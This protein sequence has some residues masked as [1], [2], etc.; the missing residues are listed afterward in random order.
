MGM[1]WS[2][3]GPIAVE[4]AR[5]MLIGCGSECDWV[6][7]IVDVWEGIAGSERL[8]SFDKLDDGAVAC[9]EDGCR[10]AGVVTGFEDRVL[11]SRGVEDRGNCES[12][13]LSGVISWAAVAGCEDAVADSV[14]G[15]VAI[16]QQL[17]VHSCRNVLGFDPRTAEGWS[18]WRPFSWEGELTGLSRQWMRAP[19]EET[20]ANAKPNDVLKMLREAALRCGVEMINTYSAVSL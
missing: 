12:G 9:A 2:D 14:I 8:F 16:L 10:A 15:I 4:Y 6:G 11:I 18:E 20:S 7:F 19:S 17:E 3:E 5:V 1:G 13:L